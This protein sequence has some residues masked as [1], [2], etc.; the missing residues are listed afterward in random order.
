MEDADL[1][2]ANLVGGIKPYTDKGR[3]I[4]IAFLNWFLEHIYRLDQVTAEDSICDKSN[5]RGIDG[6]YIDENQLEIHI[7]QSKTKQDGTIGDKDLREF[8]GTLNQL[9]TPDAVEAFLAGKADQEVKDKITRLGIPGL[10]EK[11]FEVRGIFVTN[12]P[13]DANGRDVLNTD[14]SIIVYDRGLIVRNY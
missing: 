9:R 3:P 2:Y 1:E 6:I 14:P 5:D 11:G 7:F 10:L 4:S 12:V 8:S 13:V